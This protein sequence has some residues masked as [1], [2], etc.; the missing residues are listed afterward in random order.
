MNLSARDIGKLFAIKLGR[1]MVYQGFEREHHLFIYRDPPRDHAAYRPDE[2]WMLERVRPDAA[3][4]R[5]L[6]DD[7]FS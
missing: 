2:L 1:P 4:I 6:N 5:L 7:G 3:P